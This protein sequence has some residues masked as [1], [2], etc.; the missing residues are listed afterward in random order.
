MKTIAV[1]VGSL[2]RDSL[3]R[4]LARGLEKLAGEGLAF[5][6][7]DMDLPLYNDDLWDA[8]PEKVLAMKRAVEAADGVLMVTPEYNRSMSPVLKNA[9]D[10]GSR[11]AGQ[12]SWDGKPAA[13]IGV[14]PGALGALGAVMALSPVMGQ[15]G[16]T[17]MGQP[18]MF[19][20]LRDSA[21]D[22]DGALADE[23][24]RSFLSGFLA[25]FSDWMATKG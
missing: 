3:N 11:P 18:G 1:L 6:F 24:T 4:K 9:V 23:G 19:L 12:N 2:R 22:A 16:M 21:F 25:K 14:T 20:S 13:V 15:V 8:P 7:V 5:D 10:W 17:V